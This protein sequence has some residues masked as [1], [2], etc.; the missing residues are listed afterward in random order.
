VTVPN[1]CTEKV[2]RECHRR[3][4]L[5]VCGAIP[6]E[7]RASFALER[8]DQRRPRKGYVMF[9][10]EGQVIRVLGQIGSILP[11]ADPFRND[12]SQPTNIAARSGARKHRRGVSRQ[13]VTY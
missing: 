3:E 1:A 6:R 7:T 2:A 9:R 10:E 11:H 13:I 4:Q 12:R 8:E 5:Q